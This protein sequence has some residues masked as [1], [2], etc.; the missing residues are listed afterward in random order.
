MTSAGNQEDRVPEESLEAAKDD[1]GRVREQLQAAAKGETDTREL[2]DAV[3][4]YWREHEPALRAAAASLTEEVRLQTLDELYKWRER[5]N[6]QLQ[7]RPGADT[8]PATREEDR[9]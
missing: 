6:A 4:G 1:L 2:K 9:G 3:E 5:L 8:E 7:H